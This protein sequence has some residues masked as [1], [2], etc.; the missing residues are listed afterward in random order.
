MRSTHFSSVGCFE[1]Y[2]QHLLESSLQDLH[3]NW[4]MVEAAMLC[5]LS[6]DWFAVAYKKNQEQ[7]ALRIRNMEGKGKKELA[8]GDSSGWNKLTEENNAEVR[9]GPLP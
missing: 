2:P 9:V 7:E 3:H 4:R 5:I 1:L 6:K 8:E